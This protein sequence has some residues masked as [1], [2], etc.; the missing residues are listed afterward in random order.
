MSSQTKRSYTVRFREFIYES[1]KIYAE[2]V[3]NTNTNTNTKKRTYENSFGLR[4]YEVERYGQEI[5]AKYFHSNL[6]HAVI[7]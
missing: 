1:S 2:S 5:D 7:G 6:G 4:D 3:S